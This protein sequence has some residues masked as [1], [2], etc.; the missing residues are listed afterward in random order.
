MYTEKDWKV[1]SKLHETLLEE[2]SARL[3]REVGEVLRRTNVTE[4][5]KRHLIYRL[6]RDRDR[7]VADC[8][9]DWRRSTLPITALMLRKHGL[10]K[11]QHLQQL[12]PEVAAWLRE[13]HPDV[14]GT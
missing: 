7:D 10:L 1:I 6:V 13:A 3:N 11:E 2:F 5:E 4:N 14:D 12:S 8:F 9:N